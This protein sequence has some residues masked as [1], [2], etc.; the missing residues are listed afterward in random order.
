MTDVKKKIVIAD[1]AAAAGVS[2]ATVSRV[3]NTPSIV[4]PELRE[5]VQQALRTF[6]YVPHAAARALASRK[7]RSVGAIV[8]TLGTS[9][10]ARGVEALQNRLGEEGYGLLVANSQYDLERELF[11]TRT[12][13]ERG[14]DGLVLVGNERVSE[15][16]ALLRHY[17][18]PVVVTYVSHAADDLPAIGL[19]GF[20]ACYDL[21]R[22]LIELGHRHFAV[23]TS[24]F[25]TNDRI[26]ARRHG[27]LTCLEQ[28]GLRPPPDAVLEVPYTMEDGRRA[29]RTLVARFPEITALVCTTDVL[30]IGA[31]AEAKVIG[32]DVPGDLSISGFDDLEFASYLDPPLTTVHVPAEEIGRLAAER[33][34][35]LIRGEE[36][37]MSTDVPGRI[38][39]RRS[40]AAPRA[41]G[42]LTDIL[43][44]RQPERAAA[45]SG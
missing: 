16:R 44:R 5:R 39:Y 32:L 40:T 31:I 2:T 37:A 1:I 43:E 30:A 33:L 9:I 24:P 28:R 11:E 26:R 36:V 14:I 21:T 27:M 3:L 19:D 22:A 29:L 35:G 6:G 18:I 10:F 38:V 45:V 15:A 20:Q 23:A 8:P 12:L 41:G 42:L 17:G 13:L 34:I 4:R 7:T 25:G